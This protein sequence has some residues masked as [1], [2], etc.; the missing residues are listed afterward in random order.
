MIYELSPNTTYH[1]RVVAENSSGTTYGADM[2][3]TTLSPPPLA[4]TEAA[5][6]IGV[7][8]ATLN[9]T[10]NPQ[11][12]S[13][14]VTFEYGTDTSYGNT[15]TADQSPLSGSFALGVSKTITGLTGNTTYHYRVVATNAGGTTYGADVTFTINASPPTASPI[16]P[17]PLAAIL[18][19]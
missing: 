4:I 16:R 2:T 11:D 13:T 9:G 15:V 19:H 5:S 17:P 18:L 1:Y 14:T 6:A 10:V 3:F 7:D 8:S 12:S